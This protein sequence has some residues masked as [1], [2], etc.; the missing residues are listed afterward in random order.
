VSIT[1]PAN[2]TSSINEGGRLT[3]IC[4]TAP[5]GAV[6]WLHNNRP[7]NIELDRD[8]YATRIATVGNTSRHYLTV[9]NVITQ[10]AGTYTCQQTF[11]DDRIIKVTRLEGKGLLAVLTFFNLKHTFFT[12]T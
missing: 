10:D 12:P 8:R 4:S 2:K 5:G 1:Q 9:S 7:I 11:S 3:V 6:E